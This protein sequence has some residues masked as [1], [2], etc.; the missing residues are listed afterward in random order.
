LILS[1]GALFKSYERAKK[2]ISE[3]EDPCKNYDGSGNDLYG[4]D[5]EINEVIHKIDWNKN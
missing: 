5:E 3:S 4:C 1:K 2:R